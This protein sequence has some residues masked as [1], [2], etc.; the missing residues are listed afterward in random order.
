MDDLIVVLL[1][2][3]SEGIGWIIAAIIGAIIA[4]KNREKIR[5]RFAPI[6]YGEKKQKRKGNY[7][8]NTILDEQIAMKIKKDDK[9]IDI[10]KLKEWIKESFIKI[11][12]AW[13]KKEME[14][15]IGLMDYNL[16]E[17]YQLLLDN[18]EKQGITNK[19]EIIDIN[20]VDF[21]SYTED[22]GKEI[23]E[24]AINTVG[25]IYDIEKT[26]NLIIHGSN[27]IKQRTT[28]KLTYFRKNGAQTQ[29]DVKEYICPNCGSTLIGS[30]NKCNY[31]NTLILNDFENWSLNNI[32]RY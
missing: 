14:N 8:R 24:V 30:T 1:Q 22:Y 15:V 20:Y 18:N 21:S 11:Q 19:V 26:S 5:E 16:Y 25:Y 31:C 9:D 7:T 13:S 6:D 12:E 27:E 3:F 32:E 28:Y 17:Q 23:I 10:Q 29:S 2:L 4:I